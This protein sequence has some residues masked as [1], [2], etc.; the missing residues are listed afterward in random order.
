MVPTD[1]MPSRRS[2]AGL[3]KEVRVSPPVPWQGSGSMPVSPILSSPSTAE[4][5]R[6]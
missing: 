4:T 2:A 3:V 5:S 1:S 6:P